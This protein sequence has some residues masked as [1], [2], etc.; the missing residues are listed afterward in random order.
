MESAW[1]KVFILTISECV[2][3]AGKT[4]CQQQEFELQFLTEADCQS[5]LE[6]LISLKDA[7]KDV[8]VDHDA[9]GC[10]PSARQADTF[11]SLAAID[12]ANQ[13]EPGWRAPDQA[14]AP[15]PSENSEAFRDRLANL[16]S[17]DETHW[18]APCKND[19]IIVESTSGKPVEVWHRDDESP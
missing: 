8:I 17:C 9:S 3:P 18:V 4:V 1:I 16:K 13:N 2:A 5:A 7:S 14:A 12:A 6:Q 19:G 15:A 11:E 10:A